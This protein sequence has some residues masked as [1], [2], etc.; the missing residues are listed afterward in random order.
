MFDIGNAAEQRLAQTGVERETQLARGKYIA[1]IGTRSRAPIHQ[2]LG[3]DAG[4]V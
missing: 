2:W 3:L 1:R 4:H